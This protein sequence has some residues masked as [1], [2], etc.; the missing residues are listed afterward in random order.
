MVPVL[1]RCVT[2]GR[3]FGRLQMKDHVK[4]LREFY[5][6]VRDGTPCTNGWTEAF[7]DE[8]LAVLQLP[9][10]ETQFEVRTAGSSCRTCHAEPGAISS[11]RTLR[12]FPGGAVMR[13]DDCDVRW[14]EHY[15][16]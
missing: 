11:R 2:L 10:F 4:L 5:A 16:A 6:A 1:E 15:P 14:L 9:P 3:A 7:V 12:T 8:W 13:C